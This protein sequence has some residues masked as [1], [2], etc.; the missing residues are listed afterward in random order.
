MTP[1]G[2]DMTEWDED[3]DKLWE[4]W[5]WLVAQGGCY[6]TAA[7]AIVCTL[8][9]RVVDGERDLRGEKSDLPRWEDQSPE[10]Q[11]RRREMVQEMD[12]PDKEMLMLIFDDEDG[13]MVRSWLDDMHRSMDKYQDREDWYLLER[14]GFVAALEGRVRHYRARRPAEED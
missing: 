4:I 2:D 6:D 1:K 7:A 9:T 3:D 11:E 13:K 12:L 14:S 10:A 5:Q 8:L